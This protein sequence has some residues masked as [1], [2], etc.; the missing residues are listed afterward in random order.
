LDRSP[1]VTLRPV[2]VMEL[3]SHHH[4]HR[5]Y[6]GHRPDE[7]AP[8]DEAT[9]RACELALQRAEWALQAGR[10][11]TPGEALALAGT[12]A[13]KDETLFSI[14]RNVAWETGCDL[15]EILCYLGEQFP[16]LS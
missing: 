2:I 10:L 4:K 15:D 6:T 11:L 13:R 14:A 3:H 12:E 16:A 1:I 8:R 9:Q 7:A 5:H